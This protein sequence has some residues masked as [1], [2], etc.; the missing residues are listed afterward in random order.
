MV[1]RTPALVFA[2]LLALLLEWF[3][4]VAAWWQGLTPARR[5]TLNAFGVAVISVAA[6]LVGC[7]RG[8]ACPADVWGAAG[9]FLLTALL[10]LAANQ[11]T[12]QAV[13][14]QNFA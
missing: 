6:M 7:W 9:E 1:E 11:A 12:Y 3:P 2:A 4:G 8:Q 14:R 5:T 10:A 13:K